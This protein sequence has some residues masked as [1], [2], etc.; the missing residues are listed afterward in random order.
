MLALI[1]HDKKITFLSWVF[2]SYNCQDF[3][4]NIQ[5]YTLDVSICISLLLFFALKIT[6]T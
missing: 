1:D 5:H 4:I 3:V 2:F 6:L